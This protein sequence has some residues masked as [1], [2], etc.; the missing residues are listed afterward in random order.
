MPY[1][2]QEHPSFNAS[3]KTFQVF[4]PD[5]DDR[6]CI[7]EF[8]A[9]RTKSYFYEIEEKDI[10]KA[11]DIIGHNTISFVCFRTYHRTKNGILM[12]INSK[13]KSR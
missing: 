6:K 3:R 11:K 9:L 1:L 5:K 4:F 8:I 12:F 7:N 10:I 2:L 13:R